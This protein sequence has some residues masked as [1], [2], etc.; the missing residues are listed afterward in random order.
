MAVR[1][2]GICG[3]MRKASLN[4]AL[5]RTVGETLPDGASLVIHDSLEMPIFNSDLEDPPA[6]LALKAAVAAADG[7]VFAIPEYN[8]SIP[9]GLKNA[10]DWLS[11]PPASS[12]MRGKPVGL[13]G[14]ASGMSGTIR[15]QVHMRQM[16]LFSDSP[17]LGQPEVLIPRAHERF[18]ATGELADESTRALLVRF[19]L[20]F[21]AFVARFR[22]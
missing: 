19:G 9:G 3:S 22:P 7:V 5:L 8:Y 15:A 14:A 11:R 12:P 20:A 6:V 1:L 2:L 13:V 17:C 21:V 10:L 16:M 18:D 4:R